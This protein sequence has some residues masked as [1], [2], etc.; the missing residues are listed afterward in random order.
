MK[1]GSKHSQITKDA[2]SEACLCRT[3]SLSTRIKISESMNE[4]KKK[5]YVYK[6][7]RL[8]TIADSIADLERCGFDRSNVIAC[9]KNRRKTANGFSFSYTRQVPRYRL[10]EYECY[11]ELDELYVEYSE[12]LDEDYYNNSEYN[13]SDIEYNEY[14]N[15]RKQVLD[16][17]YV[18]EDV[19][20][21]RFLI[22]THIAWDVF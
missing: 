22:K 1:K 21:L 14:L 9:C 11:D 8:V 4:Y 6:D 10:A 18:K 7:D 3:Q 13:Y 16:E 2:I 17:F 5:V 15:H 12:M 20:F 19:L